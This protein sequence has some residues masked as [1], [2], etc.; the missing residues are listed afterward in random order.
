MVYETYR[1]PLQ[2]YLLCL[3]HKPEDAADLV[4]GFFANLARYD[5]LAAVSPKKGRFRTFLIT[6]L[7][8]YVSDQ[9]DR[10]NAAKR[11][12]GQPMLSLEELTTEQGIDLALIEQRG[13]DWAFDRAWAGAVLNAALRQLR[14]E[15]TRAGKEA[16]FAVLAP[17]MHHD[18]EA[19]PY[20]AIAAELGMTEGAVKVAAKRLRDRFQHLIR[21]E[22][23]RTVID[24]ADFQA[25]LRYLIEL[26]GES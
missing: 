22:V 9:R 12:W 2:I 6:A 26:L 16:L 20:R 25:E 1:E 15:L 23:R 11:G 10:A 5:S 17:V 24:S 4:Q 18:G 3:R 8:H 7:K 19:P 21:Q 14:E 13:P